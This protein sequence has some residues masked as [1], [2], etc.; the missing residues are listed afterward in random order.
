[1]LTTSGLWTFVTEPVVLAVLGATLVLAWPLGR[2]LADRLHCRRT[3]AVALVVTVGVVLALTLTPSRT[4]DGSTPVLPPHYL[5]LLRHNPA[6]LWTQFTSPPGDVE[7]RANIA[8]YVP[9]GVLAGF[10]WRSVMRASVFGM[11]LTVA[12][13][14]CQYGI[15]G[16]AGSITDIRNNTA[17]AILGALF[18]AAATRPRLQNRR[19]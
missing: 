10:A 19:R 12:I 7:Q 4:A 11:M 13:E 9:L 14:T 17:G 3:V 5:S 1:V 2:R 18:A 15:I 6:A 8:L 16:R